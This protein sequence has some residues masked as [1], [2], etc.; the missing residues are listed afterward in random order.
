[1]GPLLFFSQVTPCLFTCRFFIAGSPLPRLHLTLPLLPKSPPTDLLS[2]LPTLHSLSLLGSAVASI[3]VEAHQEEVLL[4]LWGEG[5]PRQVNQTL[6]AQTAQEYAPH[7]QTQQADSS[8]EIQTLTTCS[9]L[10]IEEEECDAPT[11]SH[12]ASQQKNLEAQAVKKH[13]RANPSLLEGEREA[14]VTEQ[15]L[16]AATSSATCDVQ[17]LPVVIVSTEGGPGHEGSKEEQGESVVVLTPSPAPPPPPALPSSAVAPRP[18]LLW[19]PSLQHLSLTCPSLSSS[20]LALLSSCTNL[21]SLHL[22]GA[23]LPSPHLSSLLSSLPRLL[24]LCLHDWDTLTFDA[25]EASIDSHAMQAIGR[26]T[27]LT[28]LALQVASFSSSDLPCLLALTS[29]RSLVLDYSLQHLTG[30]PRPEALQPI[31]QLSMLE[32]LDL[33][34]VHHLMP[35]E[36]VSRLPALL[37]LRSLLIECH[38]SESF[39]VITRRLTS[40]TSLTLHGC[41]ALSAPSCHQLGSITALRRLELWN[42]DPEECLPALTSLT[43]LHTLRISFGRNKFSQ[44]HGEALSHMT[45][46]QRLGLPCV[47]AQ[48]GA[49]PALCHG[50]QGLTRLD[51]LC[52]KV[53]DNDLEAIAQLPGLRVLDLMQCFSITEGGL[54]ALL[55]DS[56]FVRGLDGVRISGTNIAR[57]VLPPRI[58]CYKFDE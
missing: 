9:R 41:F 24:H 35:L 27:G 10:A 58:A 15:A 22:S 14:D 20:A 51:L 52:S 49:V 32:R 26:L 38:C 6:A 54:K 50:L 3:T 28:S 43:A 25:F 12:N 17:P 55:Q 23:S 19:G 2:L 40:L 29:L 39:D 42:V 4:P 7:A 48:R 30:V 37:H 11:A 44:L 5:R 18:S 47:T 56:V 36:F 1:M 21:T 34:L 46:L 8:F 57:T 45:W 33:T 16:S 31:V 13:T 53:T